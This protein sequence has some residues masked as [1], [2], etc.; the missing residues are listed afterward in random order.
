MRQFAEQGYDAA[1]VGDLAAM[2]GIAKGSIFQHF[3]TKDGLFLRSTRKRLVRFRA[4]WMRRLKF[5][6]VD[7]SKCLRYWL[8]RTEHLVHEDWIPYRVSLLGNYG[9]SLA[10]KTRNQ[11]LLVAEDPV[12]HGGFV[13]FGLQRGEVRIDLDLE[14][15]VSILDWTIG[16]VSG[17]VVDRG[18]RSRI[19]STPGR[20]GRE[21]G[22]SHQA[23]SRTC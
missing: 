4:I 12:W 9:T 23:V 15:I 22:S 8:A 18:T 2:L 16:A 13:R 17:C 11:S 1:R 14:M 6:I 21:K 3:G 10:L 7:S 20:P 19:V 5:A